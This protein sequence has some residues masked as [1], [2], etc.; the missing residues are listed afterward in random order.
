[1]A[2][3]TLTDISSGYLTQTAYNA[4]NTLIEAALENTLSR[5]GTAPNN[6]TAALDMNSQDINNCNDING[7]NVLQAVA[8]QIGGVSVVPGD[9]LSV[10]TAANVPNVPA[11]LIVA[12]D[13]QAALDELDVEVV[14]ITGT[15]T[16]AGAKTFS[17]AIDF[18]VAVTHDTNLILTE[19]A[20]ATDP[21]AGLAKMWVKD[22]APNIPMFTDDTDVDYGIVISDVAIKMKV[23]NIDDWDMDATT[24]VNVAHNLTATNIRALTVTIR[25]DTDTDFRDLGG[26]YFDENIAAGHYDWDATLVKMH[27]EPGGWFDSTAFD[28][29]SF[30]RGWI[31][32][33]YV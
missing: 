27:R 7:V 2:K 13:V 5:D 3:L 4:N 23:I 31:T 24:A 8:V 21:T 30:N 15:Q 25:A 1:M 11:G 9:T 6:M 16:V 22:D 32:I 20:A 26:N 28:S 19:Q 29:T 33:W 10:A 17:D 14:R 12:T 18:T